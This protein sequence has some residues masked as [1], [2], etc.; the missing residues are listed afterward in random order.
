MCSVKVGTRCLNC[1]ERYLV[2]T[3][4]DKGT[5]G[6]IEGVGIPTR[7]YFSNSSSGSSS[8]SASPSSSS[9][10]SSSASPES[11]VVEVDASS[12]EE[13]GRDADLGSGSDEGE[14][15]SGP[16]DATPCDKMETCLEFF[17]NFDVPFVCPGFRGKM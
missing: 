4:D 11:V 10:S 17:H 16:P 13:N 8:S 6:D 12:E 15:E 14:H 1:I 5:T 2:D 3:G 7:D 9:S